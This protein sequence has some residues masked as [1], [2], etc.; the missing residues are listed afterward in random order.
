MAGASNQAELTDEASQTFQQ[1]FADDAA[2][3]QEAP[4]VKQQKGADAQ[5]RSKEHLDTIKK[6]V[7]AATEQHVARQDWAGRADNRSAALY[8]HGPILVHITC[9]SNTRC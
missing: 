5:G 3:A 4:T 7:D 1:L 2:K 6:H 8:S 9:L